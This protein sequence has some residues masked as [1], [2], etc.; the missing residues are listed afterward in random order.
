MRRKLKPSHLMKLM[1]FINEVADRDEIQS[2]LSKVSENDMDESNEETKD[3]KFVK[4]SAANLLEI[5]LFL[6]LTAVILLIDDKKYN[7]ACE[8]SSSLIEK[9]RKNPNRTTIFPVVSKAYFYYSRSFELTNRLS[10]IRSNLLA[11]Y[12]TSSLQHDNDGQLTILNLLLRYYLHYNLVE[13]AEK[14]LS[15]V[16]L[17]K[18]V[19][20][21]NNQMARYKKKKNLFLQFL[22]LSADIF[23]TKEESNL[24]N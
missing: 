2:Y 21:S 16:T 9:I 15:K 12:R 10:E 6:H 18:E 13:Q 24:F 8:A 1:S 17:S 7:E 4:L 3:D 22:S 5:T 11:A 23:S 14:L 19:Q 20:S